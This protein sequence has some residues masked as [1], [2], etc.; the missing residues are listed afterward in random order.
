MVAIWRAMNV[1]AKTRPLSEEPTW[2]VALVWA[3]RMPSRCELAPASTGPPTCQKMLEAMAPPRSSTRAPLPT[4]SAPAILKMKTSLAVPWMKSWPVN[5]TA[6]P[7]SCTPA[8]KSCP[9]MTP[10]I[11]LRFAGSA[12]RDAASR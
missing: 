3:R 4:T 1:C 7:H 10:P 6:L 8:V 12:A 11:R 2:K 5:E 9:V